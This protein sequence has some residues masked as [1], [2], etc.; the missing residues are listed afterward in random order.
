MSPLEERTNRPGSA[1]KPEWKLKMDKD[2]AGKIMNADRQAYCSY[3]AHYS[4]APHGTS[5]FLTPLQLVLRRTRAAGSPSVSA[6][7]TST[8]SLRM[9]TR[10]RGGALPER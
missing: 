7:I 9:A 10:R 6:D 4:I 1:A 2:F 3:R 5:A 8:S